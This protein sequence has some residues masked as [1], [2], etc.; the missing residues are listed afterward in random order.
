MATTHIVAYRREKREVERER[1]RESLQ[2][3]SSITHIL[4]PVIIVYQESVLV[5]TILRALYQNLERN[6][7]TSNIYFQ[8]FKLKSKCFNTIITL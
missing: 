4:F 6:F 8:T 2:T 5:I 3:F 1:E 7:S